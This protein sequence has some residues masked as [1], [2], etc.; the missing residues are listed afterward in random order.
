[1]VNHATAHLLSRREEENGEEGDLELWADPDEGA[2]H[3]LDQALPAELKVQKVVIL[4]W[5]HREVKTT[6]FKKKPCRLGDAIQQPSGYRPNSLPTRL[7]ATPIIKVLF[8]CNMVFQ[9]VDFLI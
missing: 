1:M 6:V 3:R 4:I 9:D 8:M 5:L 7:P 2:S